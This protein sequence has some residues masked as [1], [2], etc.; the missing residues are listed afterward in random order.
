[1]N[2]KGKSMTGASIRMLASLM[3]VSSH[4]LPRED[5]I[6]KI[7]RIHWIVNFGSNGVATGGQN[8]EQLGHRR[9]KQN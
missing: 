1:M 9:A 3:L 8:C 4:I 2:E 5:R 6:G 7:V